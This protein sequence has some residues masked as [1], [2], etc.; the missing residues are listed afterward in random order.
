[1]ASV[2][3]SVKRGIRLFLILLVI[4]IVLLLS[5]TVTGET[6]HALKRLPIYY[7]LIAL[8]FWGIYILFDALRL[9]VIIHG[10]T[11]RWLKLSVSFDIIL[12]GSFMAAVTPFQTGGLPVQLYI[13]H[14]NKL[15][16]GKGTLALL[17]R[18]IFYALFIF[19]LIPFLLPLYRSMEGSKLSTILNYSKFVYIFV[20]IAFILVITIPEKIKNGLLKLTGHRENKLKRVIRKT[21]DEIIDMKQEFWAFTKKKWW[22]TLGAYILSFLSYIPYYSI[23]PLILKGLGIDVNYYHVFFLQVFLILFTFFFPT[24]GGTGAVEGGFAVLF[25]TIAPRHILGVYTLIWRFFTSYITAIVGGFLTLKVLKL[26]DV[27]IEENVESEVDE[28]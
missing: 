5:L 23:A 6:W 28:P 13:L 8:L 25:T 2:R 1:L 24:P 9:L 3:T 10:I 18:G 21:F 4:T 19:T 11:G 14:K 16:I 12:T 22:H 7:F 26:G 17:L 20:I 27:E 15:S